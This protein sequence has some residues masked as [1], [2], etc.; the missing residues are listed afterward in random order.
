MALLVELSGEQPALGAE[1]ALSA[2]S[3]LA[4]A[5]AVAVLQDGPALLVEAPG[6]EG[7]ALAGRLGLAHAVLEGPVSGALGS[8]VDLAASVGLQGAA[9]FVVRARRAG[10]DGGD[11]AAIDRPRIEAD[12]GEAIMDLTGARVDVRS[13]DAEV[14]LLLCQRAHA[15]LVA[16]RVDRRAMDARAGNRRPF[17]LPV[18]I[19]PK[20]ARAMVNMARAPLGGRVVDPFCGTGG[21]LIEAALLGYRAAGGDLDQRMVEGSR[22]NLAHQGVRAELAMCDVS[23]FPDRLP[24]QVDAIVTDPPYGKSTWT[25]GEAVPELLGRF[26]RT[27][28]RALRPG[29]RLVVCLPDPSQ[30]PTGGQGFKLVSVHALRVHRSLTRHIT[31]LVRA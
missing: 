6:V 27:A 5:E 13:P 24:G 12:A 26:Y 22:R 23:D 4:G 10:G 30:A 11:A 1:E 20:Y 29:S 17:D 14:R 9:S 3:V 2:A 31:T 21:V 7:G 8:A 19:H 16:G 28:A 18:S 15:G 25:D